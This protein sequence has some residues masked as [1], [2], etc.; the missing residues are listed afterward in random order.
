MTFKCNDCKD[1]GEI[2][3]LHSVV[4]CVCRTTPT[5]ETIEYQGRGGPVRVTV[6]SPADVSIGSAIMCEHA[7]EMPAECVCPPNCYCNAPSCKNRASLKLTKGYIEFRNSSVIIRNQ[8]RGSIADVE[9]IPK[10]HSRPVHCFRDVPYQ[11]VKAIRNMVQYGCGARKVISFLEEMQE[12]AVAYDESSTLP[13]G[14]DPQM[15]ERMSAYI[16]GETDTDPDCMYRLIATFLRREHSRRAMATGRMSGSVPNK[17]S[18]PKSWQMTHYDGATFAPEGAKPTAE[19]MKLEF[20]AEQMDTAYYLQ[21]LRDV[22]P[23]TYDRMLMHRF[24]PK[25]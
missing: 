15:I 11:H 6:P 10:E 17:Q 22:D 12:V 5:G 20:V 1:T 2:K 24:T 7:N 9:V 23:D 4:P 16:G 13:S 3:L 21:M 18:M 19:S 14:I 25:P 8:R